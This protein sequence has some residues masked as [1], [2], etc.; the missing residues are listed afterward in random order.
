MNFEKNILDTKMICFQ[1]K[2]SIFLLQSRS[3]EISKCSRYQKSAKIPSQKSMN[4]ARLIGYSFR[5]VNIT[6]NKDHDWLKAG[7]V[8]LL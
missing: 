8:V 1:P 7:K 2:L 5:K 6:E 3:I 4:V